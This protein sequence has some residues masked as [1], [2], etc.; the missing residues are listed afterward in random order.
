MTK[1]SGA[2]VW[3]RS[4]RAQCDEVARR[5]AHCGHFFQLGIFGKKDI[6]ILFGGPHFLV[7]TLMI[8]I[9]WTAHSGTSRLTLKMSERTAA[10]S[11]PILSSTL[12]TLGVCDFELLLD[13]AELSNLCDVN[14]TKIRRAMQIS[15]HNKRENIRV[16]Q[17]DLEE[18][19]IKYNYLEYTCADNGKRRRVISVRGTKNIKNMQSNM[20]ATLVPFQPVQQPQAPDQS[21]LVFKVHRGYSLLME[22]IFED[23]FM[24]KGGEALLLMNREE[25]KDDACPLLITGHSMGGCVGIL[26]ALALHNVGVKIEKVVTFGMPKF[27]NAA[28]AGILTTFPI[29]LVE[30]C[31]DPIC[32]E[33][34][35]SLPK[36]RPNPFVQ[37]DFF[38]AL[39][40]KLL[41]LVPEESLFGMLKLSAHG[42]LLDD[43]ARQQKLES[44]R[45]FPSPLLPPDLKFHQMNSYQEIL[46]SLNSADKWLKG[47]EYK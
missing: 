41:L 9:M 15:H 12:R 11:S 25:E 19:G 10:S 35:L 44:V 38:T 20:D 4:I 29:I 21:N 33:P 37:L 7:L 26:L 39:Q 43:E 1:A 23:F 14:P 13:M 24:R 8:A 22:A 27:C 5:M 46:V 6:M 17:R 45:K 42:C 28:G 47:V 16:L 30:H 34:P 36:I 18:C 31:K 3:P 2:E 40:N 32:I